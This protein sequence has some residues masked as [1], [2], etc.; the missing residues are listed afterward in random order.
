[1]GSLGPARG[2]WDKGFDA[3]LID[4]DDTLYHQPLIPAAVRRNIAGGC[5]CGLPPFPPASPCSAPSWHALL[6]AASQHAFS[7]H[8]TLSGHCSGLHAAAHTAPSAAASFRSRRVRVCLHTRRVHAQAPA[9][10]T[11][12]GVCAHSAAVLP[13]RHNHGGPGS[14]G[15]PAGLRPLS[16]PRARH[17]GL[18][19]PAVSTA[20]HPPDVGRHGAAEAHP[21]KR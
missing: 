9:N 16:R 5:V 8:A 20:R 13:V 12:R 6:F 19:E 7:Q 2:P 1:M 4:L 3:I 14:K 17:P 11:E 21:H 18:P 10:P 15:L